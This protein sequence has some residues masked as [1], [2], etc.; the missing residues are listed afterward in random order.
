MQIFLKY[1][2]VLTLISTAIA[3]EKRAL[4]LED[5][6]KIKQV[7]S[8]QI[9]PN[10]KYIAFI[11]TKPR[12]L[13]KDEDGKA[14]RELYVSD[15]KGNERPFISGKVS[16]GAISWSQDSQHIYFLAKR[17]DDKFNSLYAIPVD[18]GEATRIYA[19]GASISNYEIDNV[20][21]TLMFIAKEAKPKH[22]AK[23]KKKGFKAVVYEEDIQ[24]NYLWSVELGSSE[25]AQQI[26]LGK[27]IQSLDIA[28]DGSKWLVQ[29]SE[30]PL[31]D[32]K[33]MKSTF[34]V[35]DAKSK[36]ITYTVPHE[37]K[38]G[39]ARFNKSGSH[40]AFIGA[41]DIHDPASGRLRV[42]K[43]NAA[44]TTDLLPNYKGHVKSFY[45]K[46]NNHL[47]YLSNK[48]TSSVVG[49]VNIESKSTKSLMKKSDEVVVSLSPSKDR[50]KVAMVA[51]S[52]MHPKE[53]FLLSGKKAK[54]LTDSNPFMADIELGSQS[55]IMI[56]ARDGVDIG[57]ILIKPLNYKKGQRYPLIMFVHGGPES[58][59]N[60]GWVT[61]YSRTGQ[62]A[63]AKGYVAFYPNYRGSTG[64]GVEYSKLG[65]GRYAEGEFD[66][67]VDFK[68]YFVD[69]GIADS[70]KVGI[71]G[72]SYGGY[73]SAWAA[74][75]LSEHFAASV[76]FVGIS[77]QLSKFGT[78][79]IPNEMNLVHARSWPWERWQWMLERSPIYHVQNAK[80]PI[81]I[82]HGEEDTRVHPSQSM[83]LYRY[84]KTIG[85]APVRLVLYPG[86]GHG[87]RKGAAQ[88][89]YS[90]RLMRWMDHYLT[91]PGGEPPAYELNHHEQLKQKKSNNKK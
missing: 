57:G 88:Y 3:G 6:P 59:V 26:E 1:L 41:Q 55:S 53:L 78:T 22:L 20:N 87:N 42:A 45:W 54:R 77:N 60:N 67:L 80:T 74:T 84:I 49:Q 71:T 21:Q 11:R 36:K 18:G 24:M 32:D 76:M 70:K 37:G 33:Y 15:L 13:Y 83:E 69:Q 73:A 90:L 34:N 75:A 28:E 68:Q 2:L 50:R 64:L 48:G 63:A 58:H 29:M 56:K 35:V 72:G 7:S 14:W 82:M 27:H 65:Q 40:I 52:P 89:D 12:E 85:K 39:M 66:D 8:A 79:D 38:V 62:V 43:I 4:T 10:G 25:K 81:L 61:N 23:L 47:V 16:I 46:N 5:L 19:H 31:I 44:K 86:E 17:G 91:G 30:T 9:S 51:D